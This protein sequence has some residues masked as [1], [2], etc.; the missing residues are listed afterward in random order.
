MSTF[1]D[2]S[3]C[4][5]NDMFICYNSIIM[6]WGFYQNDYQILSLIRNHKQNFPNYCRYLIIFR[7]KNQNNFIKIIA[8]AHL[9]RCRTKGGENGSK[10]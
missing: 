5:G 7:L 10:F 3:F 2:K 6:I 1:C 8:T 4:D 9:N